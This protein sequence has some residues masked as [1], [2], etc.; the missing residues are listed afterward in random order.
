VILVDT[1]VWVDHLR[2]GN[3][4]LAEAL[5]GNLVVSHP[6]V[7]G[8]LACGSIRRRAEVLSLLERLD[9]VP[10]VANAEARRLVDERRL[11]GRGI[12]WVDVHLLASSLV[13]RV[14]LWSLDRRLASIARELGV[15]LGG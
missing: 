3:R 9:A 12:G 7:I 15:P 14:Q 13:A 1:S 11:M 5:E 10:V 4:G 6:F 2:R 8:K